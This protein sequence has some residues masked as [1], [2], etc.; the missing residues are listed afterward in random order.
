MILALVTGSLSFF[1]FDGL[2]ISA[3]SFGEF[4][5]LRSNASTHDVNIQIRTE[6]YIMNRDMEEE[7]EQKATRIV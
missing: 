7:F 1:T 2:N 5:I 3:S 6:D 4:V